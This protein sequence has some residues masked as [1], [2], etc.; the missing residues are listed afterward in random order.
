[1]NR[2]FTI[3]VALIVVAGLGAVGSAVAG[4]YLTLKR[5][6]A[7][8]AARDSAT[9]AACVDFEQL[10]ATT[11]QQ[12]HLKSDSTENPLA[13]LARGIVSNASDALVDSIVTPDG[14]ERLL[15]GER[16]F[17]SLGQP[18]DA[19]ATKVPEALENGRTTFTSLSGFSV[20]IEPRAG[21]KVEL[22][23]SRDWFTW[24]VVA[25]KLPE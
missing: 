19:S 15:A 17:S 21:T 16:L 14:L 23:L 11:K 3:V 4:P 7:G 2:T 8:L 24:K 25:V 1:M 22:V 13:L 10:R 20:V 5:L 9:I 12:L 18:A 6:G